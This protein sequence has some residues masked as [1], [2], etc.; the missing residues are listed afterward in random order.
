MDRIPVSYSSD[1]MIH[2]LCMFKEI[3]KEQ[4]IQSINRLTISQRKIQPISKWRCSSILSY[5]GLENQHCT[6]IPYDINKNGYYLNSDRIIK[7]HKEG[8]EER[9]LKHNGGGDTN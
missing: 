9:V 2:R 7:S 8:A 5:Q 4:V 6:H 3:T 1:G